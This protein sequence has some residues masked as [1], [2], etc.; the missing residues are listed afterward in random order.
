MTIDLKTLVKSHVTVDTDY[1]S[2]IVTLSMVKEGEWALARKSEYKKDIYAIPD[3]D[4]FLEVCFSR[5]GTY[6][7]GYSFEKPTFS[8]VSKR[9]SHKVEYVELQA[10]KDKAVE[11]KSLHFDDN[12][13]TQL[14]PI[15]ES[16]WV[17]ADKINI[18][19][20]IFEIDGL[21]FKQ[22]LCGN[23]DWTE[24]VAYS[25]VEKKEFDEVTYKKK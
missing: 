9:V 18:Y 22:T 12:D 11:L 10:F 4:E 15:F 5:S 20:S 8:L 1:T 7:S 23:S 25:V 24:F 2:A 21:L 17:Y 6:H 16:G 3:S 14:K 19:D 13:E